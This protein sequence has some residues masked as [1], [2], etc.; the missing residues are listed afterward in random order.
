M[1]NNILFSDSFAQAA[2]AAATTQEGFSFASFA[3][4][5]AIFVIF[6]F[7]IIRPQS[8][9][10]KEHQKMV[11]ELK[12]GNKVI[13]TGGILGVVKKA[14]EKENQLDIEIAE[15]V[16]VKVMRANVTEV[17]VQEKSKK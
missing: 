11:N 12:V 6:Y 1:L 3:P 15:G 16:V 8:K 5:V 9:K 13:T 14:V 2:E 17:I 7:L 10:F 4:L